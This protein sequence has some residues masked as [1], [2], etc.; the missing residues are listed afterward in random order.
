MTEKLLII[1]EATGGDENVKTAVEV[2]DVDQKEPVLRH[3]VK[4]EKF[5]AIANL[6]RIHCMKDYGI[7]EYDVRFQPLVDATRIRKEL[8]RKTA[9]TIGTI[10]QYD[11]AETIYLPMKLP[12]QKTKKAVEGDQPTTL[13]FTF[14][15]Q[16]SLAECCHF[17]NLLFER[18]MYNLEFQ[19]IGTKF[20]DPSAP[21]M[22]PQH[23][24]EGNYFDY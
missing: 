6:I 22:V 8:L 14:R 12:S 19:R 24:L 5:S 23:T 3:G 11:G 9:D 7:Y 20:F 18:I 13:L 4:G 16:R 1:E 17:Y 10:F 15:R 21:K 2:K